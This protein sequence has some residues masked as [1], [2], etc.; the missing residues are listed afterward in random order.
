MYTEIAKNKRR[1]VFL[2]GFFLIFITLLCWI[3]SLAFDNQ[4]ILY[5]GISFSILYAVISYYASASMVLGIS[6]AKQIEK[7]DNPTL[8]RTVE[9]LAITAGLP[10]PKVY[11]INDSAPNAFATG[12]DPK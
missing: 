11:I 4:V 6:K 8:Y 9:N 5:L 12:R 10:M 2:I 7:K 1:S 3:F